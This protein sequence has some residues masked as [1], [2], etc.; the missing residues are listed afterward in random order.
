M[1]HPVLY[2]VQDESGVLRGHFSHGGAYGAAAWPASAG[3]DAFQAELT[4]PCAYG[5]D[6]IHEYMHLDSG[7]LMDCVSKT[8][9]WHT[10]WDE[11]GRARLEHAELARAFPGWNVR[12]AVEGAWSFADVLGVP[13]SAVVR[14]QYDPQ[15][16]PLELQAADDM[17][18]D[19]GGCVLTVREAGETRSFPLVDYVDYAITIGADAAIGARWPD[20]EFGVDDVMSGICVDVERR[21]VQWW[22]STAAETLYRAAVTLWPGWSFECIGDRFEVHNSFAGRRIA[23]IDSDLTVPDGMNIAEPVP[24]VRPV[25]LHS[26]R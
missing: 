6:L 7:V 3:P 23:G 4:E 2:V 15:L 17:F 13:R 25:G 20:E 5:V 8:F 18:S 21:K 26:F 22:T 1:A 16:L 12:W 19:C 10:V 14:E 24:V 9:T 11:V